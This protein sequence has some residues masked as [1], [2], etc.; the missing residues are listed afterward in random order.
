MDNLIDSLIVSSMKH[1]YVEFVEARG[2]DRAN[3]AMHNLFGEAW[4]NNRERI[5]Q[6]YDTDKSTATEIWQME[7][8]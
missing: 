1:N 3:V 6:W 5:W 7:K 2:Y 4:L 8:V